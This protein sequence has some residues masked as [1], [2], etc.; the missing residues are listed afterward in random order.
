M[1]LDEIRELAELAVAYE[2]SLEEV[3]RIHASFFKEL[4]DRAWADGILTD[5][6]WSQLEYVGKTLGVSAID[7]ELAKTGKGFVADRPSGLL[8]L[9]LKPG[10]AIVLTGDMVPTKAEVTALIEPAGLVVKSSISKK[11]RLCIAADPDSM[12]GKASAA[13]RLGITVISVDM[14]IAQWR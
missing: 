8:P 2:L 7:L 14:F 1:T 10:D 3:N 11:V 5:T 6:E 12:S 9:G 4:T 13:R